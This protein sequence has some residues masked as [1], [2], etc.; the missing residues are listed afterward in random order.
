MIVNQENMILSKFF[1]GISFDPKGRGKGRLE[2]V[3]FANMRR[4]S[5]LFVIF[6]GFWSCLNFFVMSSVYYTHVMHTPLHTR[7]KETKIVTWRHDFQV[8]HDFSC[9]FMCKGL[10]IN[11]C[12]VSFFLLFW[13]VY[14]YGL[15]F[16]YAGVWSQQ[17]LLEASKEQRF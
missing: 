7:E 12:V 17:G 6:L 4:S 13:S 9:F 5:Q 14:G 1:W 11:V 10:C 3:T 15:F 16:D 2:I 8:G